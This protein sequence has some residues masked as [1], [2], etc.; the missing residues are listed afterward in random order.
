MAY[1]NTYDTD[2]VSEAAIDFIATY[3][4]AMVGFASLIALVALAVWFR[5]KVK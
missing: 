2:D 5:R 4:V 1:S 3:G